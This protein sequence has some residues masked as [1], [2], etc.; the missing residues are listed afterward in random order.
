MLKFL[1]SL[2]IR[3]KIWLMISL[4][5]GAIVIGSIV[6]VLIIRSTLWEE[7]ALKT[8]HLVEAAYS[9]ISH[10]QAL[11]KTGA[12]TTPVAQ[13]EAIATIKAMRYEEKE[14]FWL[15]D[16]GSPI[17]KMIMH[18][19][20]SSLDGKVLD[21]PKFNCATSQR[22]GD[23]AEPVE[24]DGKKNLFV[25]FVEV[26]Q[27]SG[28]GYVTYNWPKPKEGGGVTEELFP[29]LSYVKKF[30]PWGWVVGSGIYVDDVDAIVRQRMLSN[31][32][33]LA[34]ITLL[35]LVIAGVLSRSIIQ[36]LSEV[37]EAMD[38]IANGNGDLTRRLGEQG[39]SEIG[40]VASSFNN[41]V[42]KIQNAMIKVIEAITKISAD[43]ARLATVAQ[44][45]GTN[46]QQQ[47]QE[48]ASVAT[49]VEG[50]LSRVQRVVESSD[51]AVK[52]AAQADTDAKFGLQVVQDTIVAIRSVA[53]EVEHATQVIGELEDDSR[54]IGD[55][56]GTIKGIADQTNLLALN[57]AIEAAR[58]GEQGRGFAVV[59][60]EVRKLAQS[61]QDA[62]ARIQRLIENLQ[63]KTLDAVKVM[64]GGRLRVV[65]SVE[66]AG[67]AGNSLEKITGSVSSISQMNGEIAVMAREQLDV[68]EQ[69]NASIMRINS[70]AS[71]TSDGVS[72][73]E[74]AVA[75]LVA[76][77][78]RLQDMIGQFK[79]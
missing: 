72:S 54:N 77:L 15:N 28:Q 50:M 40:R 55:I 39:G 14:Y 21:L 79:V 27:K 67:I 56:L 73:T 20:V 49:S 51:S 42:A 24:T 70:M 1:G 44:Q 69:I 25:A 17:P 3:H 62:T 13:A 33:M 59:A 47:Y 61:T 65:N 38:G 22:F 36:P 71:E 75:D 37:A 60:D 12:L 11:E 9:V 63:E 41:F 32:G 18:P 66:Q 5:I 74:D 76:L 53:D 23:K 31:V 52:V 58:A 4:F 68:A 43:S 7:K 2:N 48:T 10:Y 46:V 64:E 57:A 16:L 26:A 29:K 6:D 30:E 19:T 8:R 35:L 34:A 45:T 78:N